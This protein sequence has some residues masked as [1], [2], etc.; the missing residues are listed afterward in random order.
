VQ[1]RIAQLPLHG[2]KAPPWLF[3][4]MM[5]LSGAVGEAIAERFGPHELLRR[6]ADPWWF[7]ALGCVLG[8]DWHSSGLTTVTC[9]A[10]AEA[11]RE[12]GA[13]MGLY[14]AGGKGAAGRKAPRQ[15]TETYD[16]STEVLT[17]AVRQARLGRREREKALRRVARLGGDP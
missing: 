6:L 14:A 5:R 7:Q 12:R 3:Q 9:G 13:D 16:R 8:F 17:E 4:R 1:R 11:A 2:G 10:L 15:I